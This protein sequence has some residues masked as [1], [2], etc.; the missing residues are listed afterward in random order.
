MG[1]MWKEARD[2]LTAEDVR[3]VEQTRTGV[4]AIAEETGRWEGKPR[5]ERVCPLCHKR[6]ETATHLLRECPEVESTREEA[7]QRLRT[8]CGAGVTMVGLLEA[9]SGRGDIKPPEG[10]QMKKVWLRSLNT[11]IGQMMG[12]RDRHL[13]Q[14]TF[15]D[16]GNEESWA[17]VEAG[18]LDVLQ[19]D[20]NANGESGKGRAKEK[21]RNRRQRQEPE[22]E[23][24]FTEQRVDTESLRRF[25]ENEGMRSR[26]GSQ[27]VHILRATCGKDGTLKQTYVRSKHGKGRWYA[28]GVAQLQSAPRALKRAATGRFA[29]ECDL[30]NAFPTIIANLLPPDAG[31]WTEL[32]AYARDKTEMRREVAD[33]YGI[34]MQEAKR[35]L[36]SILF[37]RSLRKWK[38]SRPNVTGPTPPRLELLCAEIAEARTLLTCGQ[39]RKGE[40]QLTALSRIVQIAEQEVVEALE[41]ALKGRGFI[42]GTLVHDAL[43]LQRSDCDQ[44][45][46]VD[47]GTIQRTADEALATLGIS[48]GWA[49]RMRVSVL[50]PGGS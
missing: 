23:C 25:I 12:A 24:R 50:R 8:L 35:L 26:V 3:W 21:G 45:S 9:V 31:R 2:E 29:W 41:K 44:S 10:R 46:A 4:L 18:F 48:K 27:A 13:P 11:A 5:C 39:R 22:R 33:G 1:P 14:P 38:A 42:A 32:K 16:D 15:T 28:T 17:E 49:T 43:I 7:N 30:D 36:L 34:P 47:K 20:E 19:E 40:S 37:G 6:L